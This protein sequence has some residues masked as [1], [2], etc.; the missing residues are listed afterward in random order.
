MPCLLE[1]RD[2]L[3]GKMTTPLFLR[4]MPFDSLLKV[5]VVVPRYRGE[6]VF[7]R[8]KD[9]PGWEFPGGHREMGETMEQTARRELWEETGIT[10]AQF[11]AVSS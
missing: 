6:W 1:S 7:C 3:G 2:R 5:A 11:H 4:E 10:K 9:R 8:H